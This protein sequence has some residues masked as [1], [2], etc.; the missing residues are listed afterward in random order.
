M[1]D[2][3]VKERTSEM[4]N[5][6]NAVRQQQTQKE[7]IKKQAEEF[8]VRNNLS[9]D[10]MR[11]FLNNAEQRFKGGALSFDDMYALLNRD[12]VNQNVAKATKEDMLTQMKNVREIPTSQGNANNAGEK[13]S[14]NDDIFDALS[15]V[16]GNLDNM[17]G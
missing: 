4:I 14:H 7:V 1:V 9:V 16:D 2:G 11:N 17:F 10:Q 8:R 15:S 5:R 3:V 6:E 13:N 12:N